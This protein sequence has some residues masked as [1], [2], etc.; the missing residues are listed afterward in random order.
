MKATREGSTQE[1]SVER[2]PERLPVTGPERAWRHAQDPLGPEDFIGPKEAP[3]SP[4]IQHGDVPQSVLKL[5]LGLADEAHLQ[6]ARAEDRWPYGEHLQLRGR[7]DRHAR[8]HRLKR[9]RRRPDE[10][11]GP[12]ARVYW[13]PHLEVRTEEGHRY[14]PKFAG[15]LEPVREGFEIAAG[16]VE[17]SFRGVH[18]L[19]DSVP[20]R[21][22]A[23]IRGL[24]S[25]ASV[26]R[27]NLRA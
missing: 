13:S 23:G 2:S 21:R 17:G 9:G 6:E 24:Q 12:L 10:D 22:P 25:P 1:P 27:G 20:D 18:V 11:F 8:A 14:G 3:N 15:A 16:A 4:Y 7:P 19:H 26:L 5:P